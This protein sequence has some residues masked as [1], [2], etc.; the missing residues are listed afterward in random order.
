MQVQGKNLLVVLREIQTLLRV[1]NPDGCVVVASS[2]LTGD[3]FVLDQLDQSG[4]V[5]RILGALGYGHLRFM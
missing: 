1:R 2:P 3:M 5:N 4:Y